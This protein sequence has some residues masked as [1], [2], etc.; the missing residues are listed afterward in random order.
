MKKQ[1]F[2][3][4]DRREI[5]TSTKTQRIGRLFKCDCRVTIQIQLNYKININNVLLSSFSARCCCV[6]FILS[7]LPPVV[8]RFF[9]HEFHSKNFVFRHFC[10]NLLFFQNCCASKSRTTFWMKAFSQFSFF[11]FHF[12]RNSFFFRSLSIRCYFILTVVLF[13]FYIV[14]MLLRLISFS[15]E[16]LCLIF[17][18]VEFAGKLDW[19]CFS[20]GYIFFMVVELKSSCRNR[21]LSVFFL[22]PNSCWHFSCTWWKIHHGWKHFKRISWVLIQIWIEIQ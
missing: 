20:F 17:I 4:Y 11:F 7:S 16:P 5:K 18:A 10:F 14:C 6:F 13:F 22:I 8:V 1:K 9:P 21:I 3:F 12:I 15:L 19:I 2:F